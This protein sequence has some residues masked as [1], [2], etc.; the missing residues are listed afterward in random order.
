MHVTRVVLH[1]WKNFKRVDIRLGD[2]IFLV[3]PNASGKS[4]FLDA[5]RFLHEVARPGGLQNAVRERGG[6]SKIRSVYARTDPV[7]K[8]E[9]ELTIPSENQ[10]KWVYSLG[11]T[12]KKEKTPIP[13]VKYERVTCYGKLILDRPNDDDENDPLRRTQTHLEQI[14]ANNN[15]REVAEFFSNVLYLH[16]VPQLLR[17]P[18]AFKGPGLPE[19]P[20]GKNFLER[21]AKTPIKTRQKRLNTISKALAVAVPQFSKL[22][23]V[24][25]KVGTPHLEV[26]YTHWRPLGIKQREDQFSDGTLR[27]IGLLWSI[28][29][30]DALLLLEEPELSLHA[31]IVRKIPGILHQ[32]QTNTGRQVIVST[33]SSELLSDKGIGGEEILLLEP[34]NDGTTIELATQKKSVRYL[35]E[36]GMDVGEVVLPATAPKSVEQLLLTP[37]TEK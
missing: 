26:T 23:F 19:D 2:R 27:F 16:L 32:L 36:A 13:V 17:N 35:L 3:G 15:F 10:P 4:N 5:L 34:T 6:I 9:V 30:S 21:V 14:N 24:Q 18:E 7:I 29:E 8:I 12:Q 20:Y 25:D 28:L 22:S 1:N 37:W 33:H 31:G 11:I